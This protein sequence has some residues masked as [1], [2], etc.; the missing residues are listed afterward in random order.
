MYY[1][2]GVVVGFAVFVYNTSY[3]LQQPSAIKPDYRVVQHTKH[4]HTVVYVH[5]FQK[6]R[7][8]GEKQATEVDPVCEYE[9]QKIEL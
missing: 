7:R 1:V 8:K 6:K 9:Y 5:Y 3:V 2:Y 4:I